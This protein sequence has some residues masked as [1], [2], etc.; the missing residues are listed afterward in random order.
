MKHTPGPW[1]IYKA[2]D[3]DSWIGTEAGDDRIATLG[4]NMSPKEEEGNA[5]VLAAAPELLEA[6]EDVLH[7]IGTDSDLENITGAAKYKTLEVKL[8]AA[9]AKAEGRE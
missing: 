5:N 1:I 8:R 3:G 4:G 6:C 2:A 7:Q 9:I